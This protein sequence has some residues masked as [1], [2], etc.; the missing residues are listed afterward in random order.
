MTI[1]PISRRAFVATAGTALR[2]Q[3]YAAPPAPRELWADARTSHLGGPSPDGK[4]V[5]PG[6]PRHRRPGGSRDRTGAVRRL[7]QNPAGSP[8]FA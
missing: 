6:R 7:T 4:L 5:S 1:G 2:P 8:E 3:A